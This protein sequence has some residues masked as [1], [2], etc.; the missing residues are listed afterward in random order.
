MSKAENLA[1]RTPSAMFSKSQKTAKLRVV[2]VLASIM[3]APGN[4]HP[5][6]IALCGTRPAL[7]AERN[8]ELMF[9]ACQGKRAPV[10]D[11]QAGAES[12]WLGQGASATVMNPA[13]SAVGSPP[14]ASA[15]ERQAPC[16]LFTRASERAPGIRLTRFA[17]EQGNVALDLMRGSPV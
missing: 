2:V 16:L 9:H 6:Y 15:P 8:P 12:P 11:A 3:V 14:P 1:S 5:Y 10:C 13:G 7:R 17:C 4:A